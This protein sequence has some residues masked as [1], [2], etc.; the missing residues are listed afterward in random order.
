[1]N[2]NSQLAV[3]ILLYSVALIRVKV[4]SIENFILCVKPLGLDKISV[5]FFVHFYRLPVVKLGFGLDMASGHYTE[6]R[7]IKEL[8]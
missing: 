4:N 8:Q 3:E 5:F 2:I 1:M 6:R 7:Q